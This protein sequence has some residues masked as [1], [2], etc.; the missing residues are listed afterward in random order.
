MDGEGEPTSIP[1]DILEIAQKAHDAC[2]RAQGGKLGRSASESPNIEALRARLHFWPPKHYEESDFDALREKA[3]KML[4]HP[5]TPTLL[6]RYFS[7]LHNWVPFVY[8]VDVFQFFREVLEHAHTGSTTLSQVKLRQQQS[9]I[10]MLCGAE[11][12][13][14]TGL[15]LVA[16][17]KQAE[18]GAQETLPVSVWEYQMEMLKLGWALL[19]PVRDGRFS[20]DE[21]TPELLL[22]TRCFY[23][24]LTG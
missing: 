8:S 10:L 12:L 17:G 20:A 18:D 5:V 24:P 15:H 9:L 2:V 3:D 14:G 13:H 7:I 22:A 23:M 6:K 11:I 16:P 1:W 21:F 4:S 19:Q